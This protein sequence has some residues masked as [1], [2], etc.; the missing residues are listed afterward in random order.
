MSGGRFDY[1]QNRISDIADDIAE[2]VKYNDW[3]R[4]QLHDEGLDEFGSSGRMWSDWWDP[5]QYIDYRWRGRNGEWTGYTVE[6]VR[7]HNEEKALGYPPEI[8]EKFKEAERVLRM[9]YVYAQRIDWL[10]SGDD[11]ED[12]FLERLSEDLRKIRGKP[13]FLKRKPA[14]KTA[15]GKTSKNG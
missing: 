12:S 6:E 7:K 2:I 10:L 13:V 11:G 8:I 9:A 5:R 14:R 15:K 3:T 1:Q 4:Q